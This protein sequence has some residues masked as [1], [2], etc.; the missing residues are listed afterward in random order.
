MFLTAHTK[1]A[2]SKNLRSHW[3]FLAFIYNRMSRKSPPIRSSIK[4]RWTAGGDWVTLTLGCLS[5]EFLWRILP[6]E[7]AA[8][9]WSWSEQTRL[10][11]Q[12]WT[13]SSHCNTNQK[14]QMW[15]STFIHL[16]WQRQ[17]SGRYLGVKLIWMILASL[18]PR[19]PKPGSTP[20]TS[21]SS[22]SA[23]KPHKN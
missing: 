18:D 7:A 19:N 5:R 23:H 3:N 4:I 10:P 15:I 9:R 8:W 14:V 21:D 22:D 11:K 2:G 16:L 20:N 12:P 17:T 1:S 6:P 13:L